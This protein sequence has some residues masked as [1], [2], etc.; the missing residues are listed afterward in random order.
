MCFSHPR[1]GHGVSDNLKQE[2]THTYLVDEASYNEQVPT[3]LLMYVYTYTILHMYIIHTYKHT[4][5]LAKLQQ[6]YTY[7][8]RQT[9][10]QT[11]IL[12]DIEW[13]ELLHIYTHTYIF[14]GWSRLLRAG[15]N[16]I[17]YTYIHMFSAHL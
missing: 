5:I 14:G 16:L 6:L 10:R 4:Y 13:M 15:S 12:S 9:D 8:D 2:H 17:T 11:D 1:R 3:T 7:T